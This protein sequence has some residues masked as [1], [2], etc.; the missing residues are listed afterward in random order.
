MFQNLQQLVGSRQ[1]YCKNKYGAV[2][3]DKCSVSRYSNF[4]Q[5]MNEMVKTFGFRRIQVMHS[6]QKTT[7]TMNVSNYKD[8]AGYKSHTTSHSYTCIHLGL[9]VGKLPEIYS[10]LSGKLKSFLSVHFTDLNINGI[11]HSSTVL[12]VIKWLKMAVIVVIAVVIG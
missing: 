6:K 12:Y 11:S 8:N 4:M 5:A 7:C 9:W 2:F 3:Y 1:S 10:N